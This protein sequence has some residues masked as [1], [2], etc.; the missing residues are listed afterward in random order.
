MLGQ[1]VRRVRHDAAHQ[2]FGFAHAHP[3]DGITGKLHAHERFERFLP[4][5]FEHS[6]L[7]DAE[8]GIGIAQSFEF[9]AAAFGP[10]QTHGHTLAGL[11][12][13]G[14]PPIGLVGRA[15]IELHHDV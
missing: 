4:Q 10:A 7:H 6:A 3:A 8:Q 9:G 12:L 5:V 2:V 14:E 11:L 1:P 15:L 13:G